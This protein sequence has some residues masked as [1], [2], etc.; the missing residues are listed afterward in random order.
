M[1]RVLRN[2]INRSKPAGRRNPAIGV[3][4]AKWIRDTRNRKDKSK[5]STA[6]KNIKIDSDG[7]T[8]NASTDDNQ[9][10]QPQEGNIQNGDIK[11]ENENGSKS[12]SKKAGSQTPF[13]S[14]IF[15]QLPQNYQDYLINGILPDELYEP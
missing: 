13:G 4:A 7:S 15:D 12:E 14:G 6:S 2:P 1:A 10:E 9:K 3:L 8:P 5:Q 11:L